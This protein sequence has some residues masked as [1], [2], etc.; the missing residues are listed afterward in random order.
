MDHKQDSNQNKEALDSRVDFFQHYSD[1]T[2][3]FGQLKKIVSMMPEG[4]MLC[5]SIGGE[6]RG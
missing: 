6:L 4:V 5:V 1:E 3:T 2:V